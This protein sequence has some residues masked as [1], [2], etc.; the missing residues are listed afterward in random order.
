[1]ALGIS[2]GRIKEADGSLEQEDSPNHLE[3]QELSKWSTIALSDWERLVRKPSGP[4]TNTSSAETLAD[5]HSLEDGIHF[6]VPHTGI[7]YFD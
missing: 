7:L 6:C 2:R 3:E 5:V 1:M 4:C